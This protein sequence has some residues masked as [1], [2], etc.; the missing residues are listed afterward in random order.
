MQ[1]ASWNVNSVRARLDH[2]ERWIRT[3]QPDVLCL[4][5]TKVV[6][7]EFPTETFARLGYEM[8]RI[9]Q[10]SYNGVAVLSRHPIKDVSY[11]LLGATPG[12]EARLIA[13]TIKGVRVLSA[14]VPNG[15]NLDSP[16]YPEKLEWLTQ[17]RRTL[18][19]STSPERPVVLTGDFNVAREAR[20]VFDAPAMAGKI[21]FSAPEHEA[22]DNVLAFGLHDTFRLTHE[23]AEQFSWWDY[24]MGAFRRNRGLRIDY[25]FASVPVTSRLLRAEIDKEP[26]T[27]EKPSDHTPVLIE[28]DEQ[29]LA[30]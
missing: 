2:V 29:G 10:R 20:D 18:D 8:V 21:H 25:I 3:A 26:R 16:S 11:G 14:Y 1:I 5:E 9:G 4:Q 17:L 24:R 6:D 13:G 27:W 19:A 12:D 28:F 23:E 7:V 22:L 30:P 15:K